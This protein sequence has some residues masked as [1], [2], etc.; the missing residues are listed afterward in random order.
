[1]PRSFKG[2][3]VPIFRDRIQL[4]ISADGKTCKACCLGYDDSQTLK[5][6]ANGGWTTKVLDYLREQPQLCEDL[7]VMAADLQAINTALLQLDTTG[8][9]GIEAEAEADPFGGWPVRWR[10]SRAREA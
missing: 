3:C 5:R 10:P 8:A 2:S 7:G 6:P 1:M 4:N 9:V